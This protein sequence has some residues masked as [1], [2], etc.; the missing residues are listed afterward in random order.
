MGDE[1][2]FVCFL[3]FLLGSVALTAFSLILLALGRS[4]NSR[5]YVFIFYFIFACA[6]VCVCVCFKDNWIVG[7]KYLNVVCCCCDGL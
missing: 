4:L 7:L 3:F 5:Q 6:C 1:K 2:I